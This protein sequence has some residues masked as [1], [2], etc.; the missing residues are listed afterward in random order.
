MQVACASSRR[1]LSCRAACA[2]SLILA[3]APLTLAATRWP[4]VPPPPRA[5]LEWV[6]RDTVVNGLPTRIER[7]ESELAPDEVLAFYR[8]RWAGAPVGSPRETRTGGW[9]ALSTLAGA[10]QIAVQV[11]PKSPSGSEG[12]I[13][14]AHFGGQR[15]EPVPPGLPRFPDTL[16]SQVTESVDGPLRS[17]LVTMVSTQSFDVNVQRWRGE[18]LRRGWHIA[19]EKQPPA[20]RDG[21]KT[22]LASFSK[23]PQSVDIA[24]AWHP[25]DRQ[26]YLTAN[27]V[28]PVRGALP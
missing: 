5:Q 24:L 11:R 6:A 26:A 8:R 2:A 1:T 21:V 3:A 22:W 9:Q 7:F 14:T 18:W 20:G 10:F 12:L 13:S 23:P 19:F 28:A 27:F 4:D 25:G 17:Q 15:A 16:I